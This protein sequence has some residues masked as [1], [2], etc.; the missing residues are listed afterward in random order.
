MTRPQTVPTL[1]TEFGYKPLMRALRNHL[2]GL[3]IPAALTLTLLALACQRGKRGNDGT[4]DT[5]SAPV[6]DPVGSA[7]A[8]RQKTELLPPPE[9]Q[10]ASNNPQKLPVYSGPTGTVR[11]VVR[12][13]GDPAPSTARDLADMKGDCPQARATFGYLFREGSE[14]RL[15]DVLVAVTGYSGYVPAKGD[16]V[17]VF[18]EG[19]AWNKR[20][21]VMTFGQKLSVVAKDRRPYVPDLMG[22]KAVAQLFVMPGADPV[23]LV[24]RHPGR[25]L[26][27]D[28]MRLFNRAEV[29]A[30]TYP[31]A[32][33]TGIDGGFEI[34]GIPVG[35][36]KVSAFLPQ[37]NAVIEREVEVVAG[38]PVNLDLQ[39]PFDAQQYE[40][41][42]AIQSFA[43]DSE[44]L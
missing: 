24:P 8:M 43:H 26:L 1:P 34:Q 28:S 30:L 4:P 39:L 11:G 40:Q 37:T 42:R 18:G 41:Q 14:R 16:T 13:G 44:L 5:G 35:K 25:F 33:V 3:R 29:F 21:I 12:A 6:A 20:T 36:A 19:C 31:T 22:Q 9:V 15:A 38:Q 2:S 32:Q 27:I 7:E 10:Q 23:V 17:T